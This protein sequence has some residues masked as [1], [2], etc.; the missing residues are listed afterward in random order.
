M[1]ACGREAMQQTMGAH[2]LTAVSGTTARRRPPRVKEWPVLGSA[3]PFLRDPVRYL[4]RCY[5]EHVVCD[6][7]EDRD[8]RTRMSYEIDGVVLKVNDLADC[9]RICA[10]A[11]SGVGSDALGCFR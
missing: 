5:R 3:L 2:E 7:D 1:Q 10:T 9:A 11:A 6:Y 8:L 4:L